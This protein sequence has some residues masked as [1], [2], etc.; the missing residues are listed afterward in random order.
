M[1]S[2]FRP[3]GDGPGSDARAVAPRWHL[4]EEIRIESGPNGAP[5]ITI[6]GHFLPWVTCGIEVPAPALD[7]SPTVTVTFLA[8]KVEMVN[9]ARPPRPKQ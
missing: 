3:D 2:D 9:E 4:A 7:K 5:M 8:E 6:D 1:F